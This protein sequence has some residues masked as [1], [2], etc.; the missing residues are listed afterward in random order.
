MSESRISGYGEYWTNASHLPLLCAA[1]LGHGLLPTEILESKIL[2]HH[3]LSIGGCPSFVELVHSP[4]SNS[5]R[6][7]L[8][9]I[10]LNLEFSLS[11]T[12]GHPIKGP[13]Q[14][15]IK[16]SL[17]SF[18]THK[19]SVALPVQLLAPSL[20]WRAK[21][22]V[23]I[24]FSLSFHQNFIFWILWSVFPYDNNKRGERTWW[25]MLPFPFSLSHSM[26]SPFASVREKKKTSLEAGLGF[27]SEWHLGSTLLSLGC[28]EATFLERCLF[29]AI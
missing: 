22:R 8:A 14:S 26:G 17:P 2:Y 10:S 7:K 3:A 27:P 13:G 28:C 12:D 21:N 1:I 15:Y 18:P 23:W 24:Y 19:W 20:S 11:S 29:D 5:H 4:L 25:S 16:W 6:R 9:H